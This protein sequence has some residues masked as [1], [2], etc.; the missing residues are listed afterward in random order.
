MNFYIIKR[1][2][3]LFKSDVNH[4]NNLDSTLFLCCHYTSS[5]PCT[6]TA[7]NSASTSSVI[8][9]TD[10]SDSAETLTAT[11]NAMIHDNHCYRQTLQTS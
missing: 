5:L 8:V 6:I 2:P 10:I 7:F 9:T 11:S 4:I 1:D 3:L